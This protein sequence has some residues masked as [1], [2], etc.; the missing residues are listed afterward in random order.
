MRLMPPKGMG[1]KLK[2]SRKGKGGKREE[3]WPEGGGKGEGWM[4]WGDGMSDS[5]NADGEAE[6]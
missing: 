3:I 4:G 5:R 6:R 1:R 2:G